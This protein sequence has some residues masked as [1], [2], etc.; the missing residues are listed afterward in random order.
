M[1]E[2]HLAQSP[3]A[4][5]TGATG[6]I[7]SMVVKRLLAEEW[8]IHVIAR[9]S[10][11]LALL[12]V[13]MTGLTIHRH[14]GTIGSLF[15]IL[16]QAEPDLVFHL[17]SLATATY[18]PDQIAPMLQSNI[19]FGTQLLEAMIAHKVYRFVNTGTFSQHYRNQSY[20]PKS[21]YDASKQAYKDILSYYT[22]ST[23]LRAIT[24]ELYDNYGPNDPRGKIVPL[25]LRTAK[26]QRSLAMSPG[27]QLIDLVY[28]DDVVEAYQ[29][30][31]HELLYRDSAKDESYAV[32]S[33]KPVSLKK[34]AALVET[35]TGTSLPIEWGGRDYHPREI[36][37]PW[38]KGRRLPNWKPKM[39]LEEGIRR[40]MNE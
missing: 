10:S 29:L 3:V 26:E 32:S 37:V 7:G 2:K 9:G 21:L 34:V 23:P 15:A 39:T 27:E 12:P 13:G 11:S 35:I 28:I 25:L 17:A 18:M 5:V 24:L 8:S 20:S 33:G 1:K 14:D 19:V 31:A 6:Y 30:A 38:S 36:M 4:I 16:K 22:E 40:L